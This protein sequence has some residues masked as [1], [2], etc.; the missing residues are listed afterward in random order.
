M[1]DQV[2]IKVVLLAVILVVAL[3]IVWPGGGARRVA[4]RR[5]GLLALLA[6]AAVAV[7]APQLSNVVAGLFGVGRGA[8]LLL[9]GTVIAFV[10]DFIATRAHYRRIDGQLTELARAQA[11]SSA[12]DPS[13]RGP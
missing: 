4:L 2:V 8:D 6:L 1:G 5:L 9:Y 13:R 10:W 3:L 11:I 12:P 7:V